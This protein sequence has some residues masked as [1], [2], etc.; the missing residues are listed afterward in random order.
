MDT[1]SSIHKRPL[2]LAT[3][4]FAM[5]FSGVLYAWSILKIPFAEMGFSPSVLSL[6]FT[7]TMCF[8]CIG[9]FIGSLIAKKIGHKFALI[10]SGILVASGFVLTGLIQ[11][12]SPFLL[13]IT[14]A[15]LAGNGIGIAYNVVVSTVNSWFP[16]NKGLSSGCL[17]M[18]FGISTLLIG[19]V[20]SKLFTFPSFG[21]RKTYILLGIVISAVIILS[22]FIL[23]KPSL[24]TSLPAPK[25]GKAKESESS[26]DFA[27]SEMLKTLTFWKA[28][29]CMAFL[30]AVGNSVISF[31]RD[32]ALFVGSPENIATTLVG[33]LSVFNGVG[34]ILTGAL[35]DAAGRRKTMISANIL[36]AFAALSSLVAVKLSSLPLLI[37]SL[38]LS[39][40][41]YG[42]CPTVSAAFTESF[43]GRKHFAT[44]YSITNFSL[45]ASS[46]IA[47][48]SNS[49]LLSTGSYTA[50]F[51]ML[52]AL[53]VVSLAI[54]YSLKK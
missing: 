22:A 44:N 16:D 28:F 51:I 42:S 26:K 38:C 27:P 12:E 23:K 37:I 9:A 14:Y 36:T 52:L 3:G 20:I 46:F 48:L 1:T 33:V 17:M 47:N 24:D 15:F 41:S 35:Y 6:N 54:N 30:A 25:E 19:E 50:P 45:I 29:L 40:I 10:I 11:A 2:F 32:L 34:R 7:L 21:W 13:Y 8:F 53:S 18:G 39:G 5:L 43:F 4:V 31:A 49:L